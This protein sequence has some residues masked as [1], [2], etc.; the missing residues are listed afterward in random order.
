MESLNTAIDYSGWE[1]SHPCFHSDTC[2]TGR[3][4]DPIEF[5]T[6]APGSCKEKVPLCQTCNAD[7][8]CISGAYCSFD[9]SQ[10]DSTN[11]QEDKVVP[12]K[13]KCVSVSTGKLPLNCKC[14]DNSDCETERCDFSG[15]LISP[16]TCRLKLG[17][18][19]YCNVDSDCK[20][21]HCYE[22]TCAPPE[23][24]PLL[25]AVDSSD[26]VLC[27]FLVFF[28]VSTFGG[29]VVIVGNNVV[30]SL[31]PAQFSF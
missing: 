4:D 22:G 9:L 1:L 8:E 3:C 26:G 28:F 13:G 5:P 14:N 12:K 2:S 23:S 19:E 27:F 25:D 6:W 17:M 24:K 15:G 11:D 21:D 18:C 29:S 16:V 7:T 31:V 20:T 30:S 10:D